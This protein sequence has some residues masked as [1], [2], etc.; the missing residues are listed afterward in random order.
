MMHVCCRVVFS[1]ERKEPG[2][3]KTPIIALLFVLL[4]ACGGGTEEPADTA[5]DPTAAATD[6]PGTGSPQKQLTVADS[7]MGKMLTVDGTTVYIFTAD[8]ANKS[9]CTGGC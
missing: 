6:D 8:T 1:P 4:A 9:T 2:M 3:R 5:A 7:K